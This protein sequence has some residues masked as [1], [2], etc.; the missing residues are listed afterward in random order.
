MMPDPGW[1]ALLSI[2]WIGGTV[3]LALARRR[4][5]RRRDR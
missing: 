5:H 2:A 4:R 3:A 1:A